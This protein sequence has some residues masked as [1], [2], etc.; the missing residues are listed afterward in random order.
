MI[1]NAALTLVDLSTYITVVSS[2]LTKTPTV[3]Y[4]EAHISWQVL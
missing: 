2:Q 3:T 4:F 1:G